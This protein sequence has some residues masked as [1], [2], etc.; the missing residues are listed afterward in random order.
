MQKT[1]HGFALIIVLWILTLLSL[2]AGSFALS[3]RRDNSVSLALKNNAQ[4]LS[5][6]ESGLGLAL[7][8]MQNPN[9]DLR[10][11]VDGTVYQILRADGV[12]I[13][14][15]VIS[16]SGK[17]DINTA[18]DKLLAAV[19]QWITPD[20]WAQQKLLNSILDWR[21][22][23]DEPRPQGAEKIQYQDAGLPYSPSNNAFQSLEELQLILGMDPIIYNRM[24]PLVTVYSGQADVNI[25]ETTQEMRQILANMAQQDHTQNPALQQQAAGNS[26]AGI[27]QNGAYTFTV[28]V[29]MNDNASASLQTV[30]KF[31]E[32]NAAPDAQ[33]GQINQPALQV[34]DWRQNQITSSLFAYDMASPII[35]IQDEF[36]INN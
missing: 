5:L 9:P 14:I 15:K 11:L 3:M 12:R 32:Q 13:R 19:I 22:A 33:Q 27:S 30:I 23:D 6:T 20:M 8:M 35:T 1:Q 18:S 24:L 29:M 4:A 7:Y 16:E 10:W 28:E 17:I 26:A 36:T 21:D 31:G 2:M 25:Q 34:L